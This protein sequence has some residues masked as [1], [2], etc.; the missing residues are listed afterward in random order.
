MLLLIFFCNM[1]SI[2]GFVLRDTYIFLKD[3]VDYKVD[4]IINED[5]YEMIDKNQL[6]EFTVDQKPFSSFDK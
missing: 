3:N 6:N 1:I 2:N 4:L 5:D